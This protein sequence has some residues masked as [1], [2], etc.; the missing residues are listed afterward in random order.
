MIT[1]YNEEQIQAAVAALK[2]HKE[3]PFVKHQWE[4]VVFQ[5]IGDND[6]RIRERI[7]HEL[8]EILENDPGFKF[9]VM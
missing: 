6:P 9:S 7:Y 3:K 5:L 2:A 4:E 8:D 1:T